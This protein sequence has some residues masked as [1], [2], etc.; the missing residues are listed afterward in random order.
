VRKLLFI[1]GW[2]DSAEAFNAMIHEVLQGGHHERYSVC[3]ADFTSLDDEVTFTDL[4]EAMQ[5]AWLAHR[6]PLEGKSVSVI[7]HSTGALVLR[8]WL[9]R[10]YPHGGSPISHALLLAPPNFG[11]YLAHKGRAVYGRVLKGM[12]S[13]KPFEVGEK[14]LIDLEL[15]SPF[16][17]DL[18]SFDVCSPSTSFQPSDIL[19]TIAI[20]NRGY[21]GIASAANIPGSDGVVSLASAQLIAQRITV[22]YAEDRPIVTCTPSYAQVALAIIPEVDHASILGT[23]HPTTAVIRACIDAL[24]VQEGD[25]PA[26][27]QRLSHANMHYIQQDP[28]LGFQQ[29][30]CRVTNQYQQAV[31]DYYIDCR[32]NMRGHAVCAVHTHSQAPAYRAFT[33][34]VIDR[35]IASGMQ[36]G[37][38]G[39]PSLQTPGVCVG[40]KPYTV[41]N[42][43]AVS[44][45]AEIMQDIFTPGGVVLF[46]WQI[47]RG[48]KHQLFQL[49]EPDQ[50]CMV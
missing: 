4:V 43:L 30:I 21:Q 27:C 19:T 1:H 12:A 13:P 44:L 2:S 48:Y 20:G 22:Q 37:I 35:D 38:T 28:A 23:P 7:T 25:F 15:A 40:Y 46:D 31:E 49:N 36:I 3:L 5:A 24:L 16:L 14:L 29:M 17:W 33:M 8:A 11:S 32:N 26:Y 18:A 39:M 42:G 10:Y 41:M 45:S 50:V 47:M 9:R 34:R 6:L